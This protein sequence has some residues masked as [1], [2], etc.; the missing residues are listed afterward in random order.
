M[1]KHEHLWGLCKDCNV[2]YCIRCGALF[3]ELFLT[4]HLLHEGASE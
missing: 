2:A 3:P 1:L 4:S